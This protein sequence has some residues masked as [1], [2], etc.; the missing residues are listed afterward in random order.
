MKKY[1]VHVTATVTGTTDAIEAILFVMQH[2][3]RVTIWFTDNYLNTQSRSLLY[4]I[5]RIKFPIQFTMYY[6]TACQCVNR[7]HL[8]QIVT[9]QKNFLPYISGCLSN[10]AFLCA[11]YGPH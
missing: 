10:G 8:R 2:N 6:I 1:P 5:K 11:P 4:Q 7:L 9:P 3:F